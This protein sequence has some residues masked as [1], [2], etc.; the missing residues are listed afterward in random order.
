MGKRTILPR[1][2]SI[3]GVVLASVFFVTFQPVLGGQEVDLPAQSD[4]ALRA[5]IAQRNELHMFGFGP[6]NSPIDQIASPDA[7]ALRQLNEYA[8]NGAGILR[9]ITDLLSVYDNLQCDA[10]R[11][12]LK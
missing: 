8:S 10:D 12:M 1:V 2:L 11:T 7:N 6:F 4:P 9:A 5:L 3:A